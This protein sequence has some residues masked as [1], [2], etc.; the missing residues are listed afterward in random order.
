GDQGAGG[1]AARDAA[2]PCPGVPRARGDTRRDHGRRRGTEG[3]RGDAPG[4]ERRRGG[5]ARRPHPSGPR[6]GLRRQGAVARDRAADRAPGARG[7]RAGAFAARR[8]AGA[9]ETVTEPNAIV[10][11]E[12][13]SKIFKTYRRR[14]GL[15]A[16]LRSLV[17]RTATE[18]AAV[19]DVTF[20][21]RPGEMVGYIGANGA[22]KSTTIKMLTGILT[23]TSGEVVCNGF[24]PHRDRTR[25]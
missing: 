9:Q 3:R 22:G 25:Y 16:A 6:G 7:L 4:P 14:E 11:V 5:R 2:R 13:L 15:A 23:P 17:R 21:I 20:S 1:G 24:V 12:R 8:R 10:R 18:T 19:A